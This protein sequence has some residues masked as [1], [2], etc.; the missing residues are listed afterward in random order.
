MLNRFFQALLVALLSIPVALGS[1]GL[2]LPDLGGG[3]IR[4]IAGHQESEIGRSIVNEL[5]RNN[6][7]LDDAEL[8]EYL[9]HLGARLVAG[10]DTDD[11]P[12]TFFI[13]K[14]DSV[15]AFAL[16]GGYIGVHSGLFLRTDTESELA[17]VLA[18][19]IAHVTQRHIAR[20]YEAAAG[21]NLKG[22]AVLLG[23]IALAASGGADGDDVAGAMMLGQ[24]LL[25]QEQIDFTRVQ[26]YEA[27]RVGL[28][29]LTTADFN[30]HGMVDFFET[31]QR[32]QRLQNSR[33]PEF[34][35]THPLSLSRV[36]E[37]AQRL[38]GTEGGSEYMESR[39][40]PY[41][42]ARLGVLAGVEPL[43]IEGLGHS[44]DERPAR[45]A[46]ALDLLRDGEADTAVDILEQ[47][48]AEDDS[49]THFHLALGRALMEAGRLADSIRVF[50]HAATLFPGS[51]PV[52]LAYAEALRRNDQP[53]KAL[54]RLRDLFN[55]R[56]PQPEHLRS[57]AQ[58]AME[59]GSRSE[60]H[61]YMSEYYLRTGDLGSAR[62]QLQL[63]HEQSDPASPDRLKYKARLDEV[64]SALLEVRAQETRQR[65]GERRR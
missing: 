29:I 37:A 19:E 42:K 34:L 51:I 12:F 61:Y 57:M 9:E 21:M 31:M 56:T 6:L 16:P 25:L 53:D 18:H 8:N 22:I 23:A 43:R 63:A 48:R 7:I 26:E 44:D 35:S 47:L 45:Y 30:P 11:G 36:A 13:V 58:L 46:R 38:Q 2:A 27:D 65:A 39:A 52:G 24:G 55:R 62:T 28:R 20:R 41:M 14:D 64:T 40:Y 15:N 10:V 32:I 17:S 4:L 5:R 33:M 60:S 1:S 3:G 50:E 59:A 54:M 49:V